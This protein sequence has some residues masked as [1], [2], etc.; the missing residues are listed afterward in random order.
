MEFRDKKGPKKKVT[1]NDCKEEKRMEREREK[2]ELKKSKTYSFQSLRE[3][4]LFE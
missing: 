2:G 4:I 3:K 1:L